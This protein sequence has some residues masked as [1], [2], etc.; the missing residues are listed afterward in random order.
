MLYFKWILEMIKNFRYDG[1][2]SDKILVLGQTECGKTSF[3]QSLS[4]N[5]IF[6]SDDWVSKINLSNNRE[7]EIR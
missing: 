2:F 1:T 5:E 6:G 3:I 4:K 7:E